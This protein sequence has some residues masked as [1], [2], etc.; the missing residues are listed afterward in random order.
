MQQRTS[1][2]DAVLA[3]IVLI[4]LGVSIVHG[5]AHARAGVMLSSGSML[6]VVIVIL[7]GPVLGLI[8]QRLGLARG[9]AWIIAA[10][11][12]GSLAFGLVNHFLIP[13]ADHVSHVAGP[14]RLLF[15]VTAVLLAVTEACGSVLA[16]RSA[17]DIRR[18]AKSVPL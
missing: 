3:A 4:H 18:R 17:T 1:T 8:A 5:I 11:L 10:S 13:G 2:R 9:G 15:A 14:W 7:M 12:A 6:F 16:I